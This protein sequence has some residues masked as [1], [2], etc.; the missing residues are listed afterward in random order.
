V[1]VPT[2]EQLRLALAW[3][4]V[5]PAN[6]GVRAF[7]SAQVVTAVGVAPAFNAAATAE[8]TSAGMDA[9]TIL[10]ALGFVLAPAGAP[11]V[12]G[13]TPPPFANVHVPGRV[14]NTV[15]AAP[16]VRTAT[17]IPAILNVRSGPSLGFPPI[18]VVHAG[19]TVQVSGESGDWAAI[20]LAGR[21]GFVFKSLIAP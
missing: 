11:P 18:A 10:T 15:F 17:V 1:G 14:K 8:I 16:G 7:L 9:R 19:D 5:A 6:A 13:G 2:A 4:A 20:D 3:F 12:G 21:L